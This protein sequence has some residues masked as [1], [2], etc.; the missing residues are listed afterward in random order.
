MTIVIEMFNGILKSTI[1]I[2]THMSKKIDSSLKF[3]R[4]KYVKIRQKSQKNT[5]VPITKYNKFN[6]SIGLGVSEVFKL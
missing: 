6:S 2:F 5:H 4:P 3:S 1:V